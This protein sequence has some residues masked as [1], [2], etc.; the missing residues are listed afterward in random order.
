MKTEQAER[1]GEDALRM[2][3]AAVVGRV[4]RRAWVI[5]GDDSVTL[6]LGGVAFWIGNRVRVK[7]KTEEKKG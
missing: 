1:T 7:E 3:E 6:C 2:I 5:C 4:S